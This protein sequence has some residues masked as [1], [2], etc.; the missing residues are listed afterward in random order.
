MEPISTD[1]INSNEFA[2][3]IM[4]ILLQYRLCHTI[5]VDKDS[6]FMAIFVKTMELSNINMHVESGGN[7]N[8]ILP[9]QFFCFLNSGLAVIISKRDSTKV[10]TEAIQ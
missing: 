5:V 10:S 9:E 1:G 8:I 4:K 7:H 2:K 6:K 3:A